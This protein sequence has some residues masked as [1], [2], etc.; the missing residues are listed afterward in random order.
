MG[1]NGYFFESNISEEPPID[2]LLIAK[3]LAG[4]ATEED[5][6]RAM[7]MLSICPTW[8]NCVEEFWTNEE[9]L[10]QEISENFNVFDFNIDAHRLK[11]RKELVNILEGRE[12]STIEGILGGMT[13][14]DGEGGP[15]INRLLME[16]ALGIKSPALDF[17]MT[18]VVAECIANYR[19]WNE[20]F[21][22][23]QSGLN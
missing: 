2:E 10:L 15:P 1:Q 18:Y 6:T 8:R 22:Q 4:S 3:Y 5:R 11:H 7:K 23:I 14:V 21:Q 17:A 9:L 19:S 16:R 20:L 13:Y 12:P